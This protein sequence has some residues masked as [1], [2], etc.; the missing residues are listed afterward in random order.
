MVRM[1][2]EIGS[3]RNGAVAALSAPR[4]LGLP[5]SAG[6]VQHLHEIKKK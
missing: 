2:H 1:R 5:I 4:I 6:A 3:A